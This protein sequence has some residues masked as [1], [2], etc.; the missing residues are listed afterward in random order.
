MTV[1]H[2]C[3]KGTDFNNSWYTEARKKV[4]LFTVL[5]VKCLR[6]CMVQKSLKSVHFRLS[7]SKYE[8]VVSC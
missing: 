4:D 7:Y 8:N 5:R 6:D 1:L 3:K 2:F